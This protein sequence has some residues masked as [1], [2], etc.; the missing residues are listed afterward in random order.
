LATALVISGAGG[1]L[2][3]GNCARNPEDVPDRR[4][5]IRG[6]FDPD[7]I[8]HTRKNGNFERTFRVGE[9]YGNK[10]EQP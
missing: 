1:V 8:S 3:T 5:P 10:A 2:A 9:A 4:S 6:N 7:G